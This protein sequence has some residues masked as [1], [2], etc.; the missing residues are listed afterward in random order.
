MSLSRSI[1]HIT[2]THPCLT[3]PWRVLRTQCVQRDGICTP[4]TELPKRA[5]G[6]RVTPLSLS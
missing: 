3:E 5:E 6:L 2:H 1:R 4:S